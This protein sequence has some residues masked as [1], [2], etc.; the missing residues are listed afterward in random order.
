VIIAGSFGDINSPAA[1][2]IFSVYAVTRNGFN[3]V[4][5]S[6]A[7]NSQDAAFSFMAIW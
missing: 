5:M 1:K 7:G 6:A 3:V 2:T 4:T